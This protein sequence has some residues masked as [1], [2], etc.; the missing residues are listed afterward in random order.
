MKQTQPYE[1]HMDSGPLLGKIIRFSMPLMLTGILQLLYNAADI[2]VVGQYSGKE[3]LA[4]VGSTGALINLLINVFMGL[5]IGTSVTVARQQGARDYESVRKTVHTSIALAILCGVSVGIFGFFAAKPI[6]VWMASPADVI[7]ASTLYIRIYFL[8]MPANMLYTFGSAILRAVGDTKRPLYFLTV[9]GLLNIVLNLLFVIVFHMSVAGVAL[10]TIISQ[11]LSAV[12]VMRCLMHSTGSVRFTPRE[13][14]LDRESLKPILRIGLPAGLQGSLFSISNVLIQSTVN[15]FGSVV[16]AGCA[17]SGSLEGFV[18]TS[19]NSISQT[20]LIFVGQ[21]AGARQYQRVRRILWICLATVT[22]V[23]ITI[24]GLFT[25]FA[26]PLIGIYNTD[27]EVVRQ[28]MIRLNIIGTTYFLC[29]VM[30]VLVGQLRGLGYSLLPMITTLTG[31]CGLRIIWIYTIFAQYQSLNVL[32][33]SYPIS[34]LITA[35]FHAVTYAV[36]QR[37]I[38]RVNEPLPPG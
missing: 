27:P 15:S 26:A 28:G 34:W 5:S 16:M 12:L 17:A 6:L 36:V 22:V 9:S 23:G 11:C 14:R 35:L 37:K 29:G 25:F 33:W 7:D 20:C 4:A 19:M 24:G 38:P 3:A 18:Y 8:G 13:M 10:A 21:N 2:I 1:M 31:V 30:E 32:L